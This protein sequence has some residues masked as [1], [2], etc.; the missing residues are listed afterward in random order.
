[1]KY[2]DPLVWKLL[3]FYL[4]VFDTFNSICDIGLIVDSLLLKSGDPSIVAVSPWTLRL[5]GLSTTLVST[6]VQIFMAWRIRIITEKNL[7]VAFISVLS[8]TSFA[9][10]IW[11]T[12]SVSNS[13]QFA[14]FDS[15]RAAPILWLVGS[16]VA[17]IAI[18]ICLV[19]SLS[20]GRKYQN[21]IL[22]IERATIATGML[23]TLT[24][25]VDAIVFLIKPDTTI[26]FSW[27]LTLC[28]L[29]TI[30]LLISFN[31]RHL[32]SDED[33]EPNALGFSTCSETLSQMSF[34]QNIRSSM[35]S[36]PKTPGDGLEE[37]YELSPRN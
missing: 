35:G 11:L 21:A 24:A 18:S 2:R 36:V 9:G 15:F 4:F 3:V 20:K 30:T 5:D 23:T 19:Y 7:P 14:K 37:L 6:P 33:Y 16:A 34:S 13:P 29:Y 22:G 31:G 8:L 17:D 1:M 10:S 28:K 27:D 32:A 26:F 25:L 12:V